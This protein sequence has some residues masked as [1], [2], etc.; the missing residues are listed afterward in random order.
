MGQGRNRWAYPAAIK[1][2]A[3]CRHQLVAVFLH[4]HGEVVVAT[5][6]QRRPRLNVVGVCVTFLDEVIRQLEQQGYL[7]TVLLH[8]TTQPCKMIPH[9]IRWINRTQVTT[10]SG[11]L[12]LQVHQRN[13]LMPTHFTDRSSTGV[14]LRVNR[15]HKHSQ[16][17][18]SQAALRLLGSFPKI[19]G[20]WGST[21]DLGILPCNLGIFLLSWIK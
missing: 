3:K 16:R 10:A 6:D 20:I 9:L 12:C 11:L 4:A 15:D 1:W 18:T 7:L 2:N 19:L 8:T 13:S 21:W 5:I 14:I 17:H